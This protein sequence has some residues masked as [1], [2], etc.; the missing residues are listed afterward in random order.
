MAAPGQPVGAVGTR[1][2]SEH[3][4]DALVRDLEREILKAVATGWRLS[5]TMDLLCRRVEGLVPSTLCSVLAVD[6]NGRLL[7]L[8]SPSLP[9]SYSRAI[10]GLAIGPTVGSCG[11]AAHRREPVEVT[12]IATDPLWADYKGLA[13]SVGLRACWSSPITSGN[14][15]VIGTFAFYYRTPR[16]PGALER[17]IVATCLHHCAISIEHEEARSK[18]HQL[19]YCDPLTGLPNRASFHTKVIEALRAA[20]EAGGSVAIHYID[21]DDFK[22]VN[23]TLGHSVGDRLLEMV[24]E[25]L[26]SCASD[27]AIIARLGGDEFAIL[28]SSFEDLGEISE[29]AN[30]VISVFS[31][32]FHIDAHKIRIGASS[33]IARMPDDGEDPEELLRK[34]DLALYRAKGDGRKRYRLFTSEMDAELQQRRALEHDLRL[35]VETSGFELVY[36]PIIDL[37]TGDICSFEALVRWHR[38]A[39]GTVYPDDFIP[40]AEETGL[41]EEIGHWILNEACLCAAGWPPHLKVAVNLSLR[42]FRQDRFVL[43]VIRTLNRTGMSPRRLEL[44]ITESVLFSNQPNVREALQELSTIGVQM[45]LDDFGTGYSSLS[46]LRSF[47]FNRIKIDKS[48]VADLDRRSGSAAIVR[49]VVALARDLGMKTTAEGIETRGQLDLLRIEGC[50]EGQGYYFSKPVAASK[51]PELLGSHLVRSA[52]HSE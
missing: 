32:P 43:D 9:E 46:Y 42:Q 49:A 10:D 28:Q 39:W 51:I 48:C 41:I 25:R 36:Q 3:L 18:I 45:A 15:R 26:V 38:P 21:L 44:E 24:A 47:P 6:E 27:R 14:G 22:D 52:T 2:G 11:T 8:A 5:D 31:A 16:G 35:A 34:A 12:D 17:Q 20:R 19:A 33:G 1:E 30:R 40:V 23:D 50:T 7:H 29:L 37:S 4:A 13:L